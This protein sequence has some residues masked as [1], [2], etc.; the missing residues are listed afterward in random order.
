MSKYS[1]NVL[2]NGKPTKKYLHK[3]ATYIEGRRGSEYSLKFQ[4]NTGSR[5]KVIISVDGLDILDGKPAGSGSRGYVVGA[6]ASL[7]V[8]GWRIDDAKVAKF[9]FAPQSDKQNT[10]YVEELS[11]AGFEVDPNNQGVIGVM[12]F[13]EQVQLAWTYPYKHTFIAQQPV[14]FYPT[15]TYLSNIAMGSAFSSSGQVLSSDKVGPAQSAMNMSVGS[16]FASVNTAQAHTRGLAEHQGAATMDWYEYPQEK[17]LG[18]AFGEETAFK[19]NDTY[20][21]AESQPTF[22]DTILYDTLL[23]LKKRGVVVDE[24]SPVSKAFPN[25]PVKTDGCWV[26]KR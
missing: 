6:W 10:T 4:N 15:Y 14:Q 7:D 1:L 19:T 20:F 22:I 18:T 26:P 16:S 24:P 12:V 11:K 8:P 17:G 21:D 2:V 13:K 25:Y 3:G 23:G 9:Q 5:V